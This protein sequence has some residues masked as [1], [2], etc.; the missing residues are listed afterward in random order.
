MRYLFI[1][2]VI[3]ISLIASSKTIM[4]TTCTHSA[5]ST[6]KKQSSRDMTIQ[7]TLINNK[8]VKG[9][10]ELEDNIAVHLLPNGRSKD[11]KW[12]LSTKQYNNDVIWYLTSTNGW[13]NAGMNC[14]TEKVL[15]N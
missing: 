9:F 8:V 7:F 2:L 11:G 4:I 14:T 10:V 5:T 6:N 15:V 1:V 13:W 3:S 12:G